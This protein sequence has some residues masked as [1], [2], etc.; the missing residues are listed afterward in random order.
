MKGFYRLKETMIYKINEVC[1]SFFDLY[2]K[3]IQ[4][5]KNTFMRQMDTCE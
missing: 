4:L 2:M 5:F 3:K 1:G